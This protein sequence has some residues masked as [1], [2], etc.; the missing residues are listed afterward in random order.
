MRVAVEA[1]GFNR[2]VEVTASYV[3]YGCNK[4]FNV[5]EWIHKWKRLVLVSLNRQTLY[6]SLVIGI[7]ELTCKRFKSTYGGLKVSV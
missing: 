6:N 5:K 7:T 2:K 1:V 4:T 3:H